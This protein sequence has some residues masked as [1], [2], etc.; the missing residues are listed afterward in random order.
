LKEIVMK[1]QTILMS[2]VLTVVVLASALVS[3]SGGAT[4]R[5]VNPASSLRPSEV[6]SEG[7]ELASKGFQV[8][9]T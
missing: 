7:L 3:Y 1:L 4:S 8:G 6:N 9:N 2:L 5:R